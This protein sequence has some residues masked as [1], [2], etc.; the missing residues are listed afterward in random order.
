MSWAIFIFTSLIWGSNFIL[1]KK[2]ALSFGPVTIAGWRVLGA[3]LVLGTTWWWKEHRW[4]FRRD[5]LAPMIF[6]VL[7]GYAW[8]FSV[9]PWVILR[10]GS[11]FVGMMIGLVP[12]LT[13]LVSIP[14][15]QVYPSRRQ[16][17]GVL[18]G[19]VCLGLIM[20]DGIQRAVPG[21]DL[22]VAVSIPL[23]YAIGN[24]YIRRR[25]H[26]LPPLALSCT[27]LAG[28]SVLLLPLSFCLPFEH[29]TVNEHFRLA[30]VSLILVAIFAT[31]VAGY[32]FYILIHREGPLFAGMTAYL[33]PLGALAW[34]WYDDEQVT[35]LQLGAVAGILAMVALVQLGGNTRSARPGAGLGS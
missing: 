8:P 9:L 26:N 16:I 24:T 1:M 4:P 33:I 29:I 23:C 25:F 17:A 21:V 11:A 35:V 32:L 22:C 20:G 28:S 10:D 7:V 18:G 27:A 14:M 31:G 34:G 2:A 12:L 19:L 3:A 30:L 15:L 13:I 6:L 5:H